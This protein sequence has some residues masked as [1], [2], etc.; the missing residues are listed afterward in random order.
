MK[1]KQKQGIK[2]NHITL[3]SRQGLSFVPCFCYP[4]PYKGE[5][6]MNHKYLT[7]RE[8][9]RIEIYLNEGYTPT[10]IAEKN[11]LLPCH[12]LQ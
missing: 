11:R 7:E 3:Q 2:S 8:R 6:D 9:Y 4:L 5:T 1:R 12:G 10:Q